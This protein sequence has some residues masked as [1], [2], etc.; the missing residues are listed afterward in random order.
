[1]DIKKFISEKKVALLVTAGVLVAVTAGAFYFSQGSLFKGALPGLR[2]VG[3]SG[4]TVTPTTFDSTKDGQSVDITLDYYFNQSDGYNSKV[5]IKLFKNGDSSPVVDVDKVSTDGKINFFEW[6]T[7]YSK[8][9]DGTYTFKLDYLYKGPLDVNG[10]TKTVTS[11]PFTILTSVPPGGMPPGIP[12]AAINK[13]TV[14]PASYEY[15]VGQSANMSF[16]L[17]YF[18][19][20]DDGDKDPKVTITV[21]KSGGGLLKDTVANPAMA[22]S[23]NQLVTNGGENKFSWDK[24]YDPNLDGTYYF[25]LDYSYQNSDPVPQLVTLSVKSP[26]FTINHVAA[27]KPDASCKPSLSSV[28]SGS[29]VSWT[30]TVTPQGALTPL[31]HWSGDVADVSQLDMKSP[32]LSFTTSYKTVGKK[33]VYFKIPEGINSYKSVLCDGLMVNASEQKVPT[34]TGTA[35]PIKYTLGQ[36]DISFDVKVANAAVGNHV[37]FAEKGYPDAILLDRPLIN[38]ATGY[39]FNP[40]D[41]KL[42]AGKYVMLATLYDV[43]VQ[44]PYSAKSI[45]LDSV[46]IPFEVVSAGQ[47]P[48]DKDFPADLACTVK[49][50]VSAKVGDS[51][52]WSVNNMISGTTYSWSVSGSGAYTG[53]NKNLLKQTARSFTTTYPG[54]VTANMTV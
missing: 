5:N 31:Y 39:K 45:S 16:T 41:V 33:A 35:T 26:T 24:S 8:A 27:V 12:V 49:P 28:V 30:A 19:Q 48:A 25:K 10:V 17:D 29:S 22:L 6:H 43:S 40:T 23:G 47:P 1:M 9:L 2:P 50:L 32:E 14:I 51:V 21:M 34:L 3:V 7:P 15:S 52:T 46:E 37:T 54:A 38:G 20:K 44:K 53:T 4:V 18:F 42:A 11:P 13:V 36:G